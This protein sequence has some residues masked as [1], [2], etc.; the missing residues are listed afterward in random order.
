MRTSVALVGAVLL[1]GSFSCGANAQTSSILTYHGDA[2]RS[3]TFLVPALTWEKARSLHLDRNFDARVSGHLYAQPL[4]W[5]A[6]GANTAMLIVATE[7]DVV[8]ALDAESGKE[9][10]K[11]SVG[12]P[13]PRSSL[14]C[15]NIN[16]LGITGTPVIDP[17]G[18]AMYFDAAINGSSG[19]R[20]QIFGLSLKDGSVLQGWPIDISDM[21]RRKGQAFDPRYQNQRG[22][23]TIVDGM[24]YV[25]FG[26]HFGD[27][28]NYYGWI[29]GLS[30][31]DPG[32]IVTWQTRA[33]GGGIWTPGG[34]SVVGRELFFTTGN[35][36]GAANWSDGE[37]VWRLTPDLRRRDD[38]QYFF[39]PLDWHALDQRDEDLG[40]T[41]PVPINVP[42]PHG[43]QSLILALGKDGKAYLLNRD[44]LGGIGGQLAVASVSN[45][46]IRT[47][48]AAYHVS[49]SVF[50]GFQGAGTTCPGPDRGLTVLKIT[51]GSP[52]LIATVWCAALRGAGSPI[53]TTTDGHSNPIVWILGAEGDNSLHGYRGDTG[54]PIFGQDGD[55]LSGLHHFQ[56]LIATEDHLYVGADDRVYAF[57]F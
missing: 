7:D 23:L 45:V 15:G 6:A 29:I 43:D 1:G 44:D 50:V 25:P 35:T 55:R 19:I 14:P 33:R 30:L 41:N 48:P 56:T 4:L 57:R 26:G 40:G 8:Q 51:G 47:S 42:T 22:A 20:H 31:H 39:A 3:G 13:V 53:V 54:E 27:C 5:R 49:D 36:I 28:G 32:T 17:S 24:L 38:K 52:P 16:P 12:N 9:L 2:S 34:L 10:W 46:P 11:R 18:E 37:A 21:L